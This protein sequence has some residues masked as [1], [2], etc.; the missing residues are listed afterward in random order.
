MHIP[1]VGEQVYIDEVSAVFVVAWVDD[2]THTVDL[3]PSTGGAPREEY[4]PWQKLLS[5]WLSPNERVSDLQ[6]SV[7]DKNF[8]PGGY[9]LFG[10]A[11]MEQDSKVGTSRRNWR[12]VVRDHWQ[13]RYKPS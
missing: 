5:C 9:L 4:V 3:V 8:A 11:C 13:S 7:A 10:G 1:R 6:D 2:E 12:S